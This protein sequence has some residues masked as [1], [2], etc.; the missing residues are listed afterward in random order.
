MIH[1][2]PNISNLFADIMAASSSHLNWLIVRNHNAFLL[3][4][5]NIPKPF[6]TVRTATQCVRLVLLL[7]PIPVFVQEPGNLMNVSSFRYSGLVHKKTVGI[8]P[9]ADKKGFT[10]VYK[11]R[12]NTNKPA[13]NVAKITFKAGPRRSL[14][15]LRKHLTTQKY[16]KDLTKAALRRASAVMRSQKVAVSKKA[17]PKAAAAP[18]KAE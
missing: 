14:S 16:R 15:K 10:L 17:A 4:K 5:T 12:K 8:V 3:K 7:W 1:V 11:K 6:S 18:K 13:K 2:D 9:A